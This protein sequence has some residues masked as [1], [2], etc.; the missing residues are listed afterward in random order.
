MAASMAGW[1][2][3]GAASPLELATCPDRLSSRQT[4]QGLNLI[5]ATHQSKCFLTVAGNG[6]KLL[7][8]TLF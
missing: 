4:S 7:Q 1:N 5:F 3:S 6:R 2:L 8:S